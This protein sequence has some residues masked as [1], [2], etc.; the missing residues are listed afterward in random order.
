MPQMSGKEL[1]EQLVVQRPETRVLYMSGYT[2]RGIVNQGVLDG[3]IAFLEKPFTPDSLAQKV[4]EVLAQGVSIADVLDL[5]L[6]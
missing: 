6:V 4:A 2:N 1:A 5:S 3:D